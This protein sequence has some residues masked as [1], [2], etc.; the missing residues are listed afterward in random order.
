MKYIK[1]LNSISVI[2]V[3]VLGVFF[4]NSP[5]IY[6]ETQDSVPLENPI[7]FEDPL[8]LVG[9]VVA[10]AMGIL[11]GIA[12][13]VFVY[14]GFMWLIAAGNSEQIKKGT[15]AMVWAVLGIV[16]IFSSYAIIS[17][18]LKALGANTTQP[19]SQIIDERDLMSIG[20]CTCEILGEDMKPVGIDTIE[21]LDSQSEC[22]GLAN[23]GYS[24]RTLGACT[25]GSRN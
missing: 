7:Q 6:A 13:L 18:V 19:A 25:W 23:Y 9:N 17:L 2:F 22:E 16:V 3:I 12:L 8:D 24:D 5:T 20:L 10:K 14:G 11:G 1:L 15:Q 21:G 4:L